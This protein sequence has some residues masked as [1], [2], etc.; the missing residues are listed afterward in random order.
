MKLS[1]DEQGRGHTPGPTRRVTPAPIVA[2]AVIAVLALG[3]AY[4]RFAPGPTP[5]S[6]PSGALAGDLSLQPCS[7]ATEKGPY[8]ADCGTLVVPENRANPTSR[9]IALPIAR[10]RATS[11]HPAEPIFFLK[12]GPGG[13]NM[14]LPEA[15]RFAA[16]HD[17]IFVGY[18]GVDGSVRLDCPEV[19]SARKRSG[20]ILGDASSRAF[21][22]AQT[23][24]AQRLGTQGVDLTGYTLTQQMDDLEAARSALGY[25]RIDLISESAGTR[26]AMIYAWRYP[27]RVYRSAMIGV[28]PPGHFL[29]DPRTTDEQIQRHSELCAQDAMCQTRTDDLAASMR[30]TAAHIPDRWL[31]LP[32]KNGNVRLG[33]FEGLVNSMS[34]LGPLSAPTTLD[35]WL[36]AADG[37]ASGLWFTSLAVDLFVPPIWTWGEGMS[38]GMQDEQAVDAYYAAGGDPGSVLGDPGT[39]LYW[40]AG[41]AW[42]K[43]PPADVYGEVQMSQVET[44][45][46]GGTLD[47][48]TPPSI[49]TQELL[50]FLPNGHQVVLAELGHTG[51]FFRYE[52]E[53]ST[54]LLNGFLDT[55][56]VDTSLYTYRPMD[57]STGSITFTSVA[58]G[59]LA[60]MLGFGLLAVLCLL[61]IRQQ[62]H[63][64]EAFGRWTSAALRSLVPVVLGLGGWFVGALIVLSI[65]PPVPLD[66][67]I[68]ATVAVGI[69]IGLAV[70]W[71]WLHTDWSAR[72]KTVGFAGATGGALLGAWLGFNVTGGLLALVP[73]IVGAA[74][75]ANLALL[76]L[77][78]GWDWDARDHSLQQNTTANLEALRTSAS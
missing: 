9:L 41:I 43:N 12:G 71:A 26:G 5:I 61:W 54:H 58:K 24:C 75:G 25:S 38:V 37:D 18:R 60:I 23:E 70:Y 67:P 72:L 64:R 62:L 76:T 4:V 34:E 42:P 14:V 73:A 20:D 49:A 35:A 66:D 31:F 57:F 69:P 7:Y 68:L 11:E 2:V 13:S 3:L 46:V 52:P 36:S 53:A 56:E 78:I 16:N 22:E 28:N 30:R 27:E 55:G 48:A 10:V 17:V 1:A 51:D 8:A 65:L 59:L 47:F 39:D 6:V 50:P 40:G 45:L 21:A 63:R 19:V 77:D 29:W 15:S 32:I 44:L 74:I 33:A